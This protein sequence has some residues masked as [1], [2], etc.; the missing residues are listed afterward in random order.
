M[1]RL[2]RALCYAHFEV[3]GY[4]HAAYSDGR[5]PRVRP[6]QPRW[7]KRAFRVDEAPSG[8]VANAEAA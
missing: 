6:D 4:R 3:E 7:A 1:M 2:I 8:N 5:M